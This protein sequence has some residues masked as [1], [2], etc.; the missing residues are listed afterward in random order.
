VSIINCPIC[1]YS[2]QFWE[3]AS[4]FHYGI[5]GVWNVYQ[6]TNSECSHIIQYPI[7]SE[8]EL[9][10][11][12]ADS[13]YAYEAPTLDY[14]PSLFRH[15]G[16][17]LKLH[18]LKY[19]RGYKHL[20]IKY[21]PLLALVGKWFEHKPLN[22]DA[23]Y[24]IENGKILDY[25][26]GS[27]D[28]IGFAKYLGWDAEGIDFSQFAAQIGQES[29]LSI[30]CGS[31]EELEKR[32][33]RYDHIMSSHCVE[34][35]PEI[36]RLFKAFYRSLKKGGTLLID[37]PNGKSLSI[38]KTREYF[39]YLG[40]PVHVHIFSPESISLLSHRVGF[41][42]IKI[43]S[44]CRL[45]TQAASLELQAKWKRGGNLDKCFKKK[46]SW[47]LLKYYIKALFSTY[48][49]RKH[50]NTSGDCLVLEIKK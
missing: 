15:W 32:S 33:N 46:R 16:V 19:Y 28:S 20:P 23:P 6:C 31:I 25:G 24:F 34:H 2:I 13:Y 21:N 17:W 11:Y 39:Y 45:Y 47:L 18:Y 42:S 9:V 38:Q 43:A 29:G 1:G 8:A 14:Q 7:P 26:S 22:F 40:M 36:E 10:N 27:G 41:K 3:K 44:Y 4:D 50:N 5:D 35:V 48:N 49:Y 37:I 12:Y 30:T